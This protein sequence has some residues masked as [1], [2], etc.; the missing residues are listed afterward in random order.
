MNE[1]ELIDFVWFAIVVICVVWPIMEA[2]KHGRRESQREQEERIK[3]LYKDGW[4]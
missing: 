1:V 4:N 2:R 3:E